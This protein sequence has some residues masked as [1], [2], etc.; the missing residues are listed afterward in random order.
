LLRARE[1]LDTLIQATSS[2]IYKRAILGVEGQPPVTV[3]PGEV[4]F[5]PAGRVHWGENEGNTTVRALV[6]FV[7]EKAADLPGRV[8]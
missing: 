8:V 7:V 4:F 3:K 2:V 1:N 6:T 5:V